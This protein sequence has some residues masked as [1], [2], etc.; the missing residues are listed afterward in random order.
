MNRSNTTD[1]IPRNP[2]L[3]VVSPKQENALAA[4]LSGATVTEAAKSAKADRNDAQMSQSVARNQ[5]R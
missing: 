3:P 2:T 5:P 1:I 4:L